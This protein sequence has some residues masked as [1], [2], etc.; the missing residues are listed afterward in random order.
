MKFAKIQFESRE[1][2]AKAL[3]GLMQR[4]RV[5]VL[6]DQ[7]FIVPEPAL[8]WLAAEFTAPGAAGRGRME[9]WRS[10]SVEEGAGRR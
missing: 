7:I 4:G 8:D 9:V 3:H 1:V 6:R 2:C 10:G 5:T